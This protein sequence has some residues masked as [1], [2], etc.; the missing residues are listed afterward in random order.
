MQNCGMFYILLTIRG[1]R[2]KVT[3]EWG[4][5]EVRFPHQTCIFLCH[6]TPYCSDYKKSTLCKVTMGEKPVNWQPTDQPTNQK[7][8]CSEPVIWGDACDVI[9]TLLGEGL[10]RGWESCRLKLRSH[11]PII[12]I[13][14]CP[15]SAL[16]SSPSTGWAPPFCWFLSPCLQLHPSPGHKMQ[17]YNCWLHVSRYLVCV[18][19]A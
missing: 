7:H 10:G 1:S 8:T 12:Y 5:V 9:S 16:G 4:Q 14:H 13:F 18:V 17:S 3:M 15:H 11:P 19:W 6:F 2:V